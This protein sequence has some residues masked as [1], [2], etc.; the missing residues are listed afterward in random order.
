M[1]PVNAKQGLVRLL[2]VADLLRDAVLVPELLDL[3][4]SLAAQMQRVSPSERKAVSFSTAAQQAW[5]VY[6]RQ[7]PRA[8]LC[9]QVEPE[10]HLL[11]WGQRGSG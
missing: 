11:E 5:A 4:K 2:R 9:T 6:A 8:P 3:L 1:L 10:P 7:E